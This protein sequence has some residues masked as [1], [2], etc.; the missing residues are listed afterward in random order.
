MKHDNMQKPGV[1][2]H[3]GMHYKVSNHKTSRPS[4]RGKDFFV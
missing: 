1:I 3:S 4:W 2:A